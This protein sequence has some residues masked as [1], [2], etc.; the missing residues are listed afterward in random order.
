[1]M[2][3]A[4]VIWIISAIVR[5]DVYSIVVGIIGGIYLIVCVVS[6]I[7]QRVHKKS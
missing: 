4:S 3:V 1:M 7:Y 6:L 2:L 5:A